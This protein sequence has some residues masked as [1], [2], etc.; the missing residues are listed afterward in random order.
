MAGNRLKVE[1]VIIPSDQGRVTGSSPV[2][3][4]SSLN[5]VQMAQ[6]VT[7]LH[8]LKSKV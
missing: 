7:Q 4:T 3:N 8:G 5:I 2:L 1:T 6:M